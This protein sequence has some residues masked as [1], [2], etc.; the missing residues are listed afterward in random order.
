MHPVTHGRLAAG[1]A[2]E[3]QCR[4][5]MGRRRSGPDRTPPGDGT[6][7]GDHS[8]APGP[9]APGLQTL[10]VL[11]R[12]HGYR[13]WIKV[14][15]MP[16]RRSFIQAAAVPPPGRGPA[17]SPDGCDGPAGPPEME[18]R[19]KPGDATGTHGEIEMER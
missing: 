17:V 4:A 18:E 19:G 13:L 9:G 2:S 15:H 3:A 16:C 1:T 6:V 7:T 10:R 5:A 14:H 8:E 12:R 11:L